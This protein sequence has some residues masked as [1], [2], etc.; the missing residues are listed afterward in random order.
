[1]KISEPTIS[2]ISFWNSVSEKSFLENIDDNQLHT[3]IKMIK[4]RLTEEG[5]TNKIILLIEDLDGC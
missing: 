2:K 5:L 4:P 3:K 1:M